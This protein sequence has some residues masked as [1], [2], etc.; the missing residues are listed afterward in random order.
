MRSRLLSALLLGTM[1]LAMV[2]WR[3][4]PLSAAPPEKAAPPE[5]MA[6]LKEGLMVRGPFVPE[7][8][9]PAVFNGD[10]RDLPQLQPDSNPLHREVPLRYPRSRP[11]TSAAFADPVAQT[12]QGAGQMPDPLITFP[13]LSRGDGGGWTPPDTNGDVGPTLYIQGVNIAFGIYDKATGAELVAMSFDDLFDGTGTPC[14]NQNRGDI[15]IL[16]DHL[17]DRW[18]LT[19]F[20]LPSSGPV[21]ECIAISQTGDP[22]SGGWYFY[23]FVTDDD[24]SPWH[25]YPKLGVWPDAY[26]MSANMFDPPSAAWVWA[27]DRAAMLNGDPMQA[28]YFETGYWSLLPA[29]L[30]GPPPPAGTPN[31]FAAID[32]PNTLHLWEFHVDWADPGNSTFTGP[33]DL[34]VE[35]FDLIWDVPQE[36]PGATLD[37]LGD[38]LMMQLQYRN[39]GGRDSLWVNHTVGSNGVAGVRWYEVRDPGGSPYV[40]QQG[41]FQPDDGLYRWMGSVAVDQDGNMAVGYSVSSETTKPGIRYAGRLAGEVLGQLPQGEA[42]MWQGTGVQ[43]SSSRWGDY[44]AMSIDPVDDCTFWYTQEY[45][46]TTG[47]SWTTR[48]GSFRFPSC[49]QPKGYITGQVYDADTLEG[50]PGVLVVGAGITTTMT[51]RTDGNGYYTMA[52]LA[53]TYDLTAGPLPPGYPYS[54]TVSGIVVTAGA[55]TTANIPLYPA[56]YLIGETAFVDD[57]V[58]GGNGNGYPEPGESGLLLWSAISNTGTTT[59]TNVTAHLIGLSPYVTVTVAD[60][61]YPDIEGGMALTNVTPFQ[62]SIAPD[63]PC[64]E[65]L[66]F[67]QVIT[68][69]QGVFTATFGFYAKVPLPRASFFSDDMENGPDGWVTGGYP[70]TWAITEEQSH[71]PTHAWS[72]SP[73]SDYANNTSSWLRSPILDLSGLSEVV[74]SFWHRYE[75]ETGWDFGYLEYSLDGGSTWSA[76]LGEY[77]GFQYTWDQEVLPIPALDDQSNVA[78][79]FR[80][81]SDTY[82]VEDGWYIDDFDISYEPFVCLYQPPAIPVLLSPPSGTVTTSHT[83]TFTW[84]PGADGGDV[85]GYNLELDGAVVTTTE[86]VYTATL[87]AGLH[88]WRVQAFNDAGYSGYSDGWTVEV[89]DP[90]AIPVLLSPPS[91]TVT[92]SHTITLTW[93]PGAGS[94]PEGYNL[95]LDGT[96][97][98]TTGTAYTAVLTPGMHTWRVRAFNI[99][100]YSAYTEM[101]DVTVQYQIFL[102]VAIRD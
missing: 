82:V 30:E 62:F 7:P 58:P 40:H 76:P 81:E 42:L 70:N 48:I 33:I 2:G 14:D 61:A 68:A 55:T 101:W 25:D 3:G 49:G 64:G 11:D 77:T 28:V 66:D 1:L 13:G 92:S 35:P 79:R 72:D 26:Y 8:V 74:V 27:F 15:I 20:S 10:L 16:H 41:T 67:L 54:N 65:W 100:G 95:E 89:V 83:I 46:E 52:L 71:S 80:F 53:D 31:Y 23:A 38:R 45:Y 19:D 91:G 78:I 21:Y 12:W 98:T 94:A 99:A 96:V 60:A 93:E 57:A 9:V 102:P 32:F 69:D 24:G 59:A 6:V 85:Q 87:A 88:T 5:S 22:I 39:F 56:P 73:G 44:S 90:P 97:I 50:V 86:T 36:P 18:I 51:V 84:E 63:T 75:I 43:T 29:N 34:D 4:V 37:T 47:S 17:A